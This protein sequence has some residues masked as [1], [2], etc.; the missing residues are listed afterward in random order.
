MQS[1]QLDTHFR[2]CQH[3]KHNFCACDRQHILW[4]LTWRLA[5]I[6]SHLDRHGDPSEVWKNCGDRLMLSQCRT[7]HQL[8]DVASLLVA[9]AISCILW[10]ITS[11]VVVSDLSTLAKHNYNRSMFEV[12]DQ[13]RVAV[14][15]ISSFAIIGILVYRVGL[16]S[17]VTFL[18][19]SIALAIFTINCA[20]LGDNLLWTYAAG[21]YRAAV[22]LVFPL[23]QIFCAAM[24]ANRTLCG[25][26]RASRG[27][28]ILIS[29][30]GGFCGLAFINSILLAIHDLPILVPLK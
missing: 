25:A 27:S 12:H 26:M 30:T 17:V 20:L 21:K 1:R 23:L 5:A 4:S 9:A 10:L 18:A 15:A 13:L 6:W 7:H 24:I 16:Q 19:L 29:A 28:K 2:F 22:W 11:A 3:F 8:R 14:C